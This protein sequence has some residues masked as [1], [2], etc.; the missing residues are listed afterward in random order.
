M[1]SLRG[2]SPGLIMLNL[3]KLFHAKSN[4]YYKPFWYFHLLPGFRG[5]AT[6]A[7][8]MTPTRDFIQPAVVHHWKTSQGLRPQQLS[9]DGI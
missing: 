5:S 2:F 7:I 1:L 6:A 8:P 4:F 9:Q 3:L